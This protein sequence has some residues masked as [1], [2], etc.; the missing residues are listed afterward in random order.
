MVRHGGVVHAGVAARDV[1]DQV[2]GDEAI[3]QVGQHV[4]LEIPAV[5]G[6]ANVVGDVPDLTLEYCALFVARHG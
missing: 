1:A 2:L 6:A 3:E 5:D 4:L